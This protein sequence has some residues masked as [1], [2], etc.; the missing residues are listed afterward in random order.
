MDDKDDFLEVT[1]N[2]DIDV[3]LSGRKKLIFPEKIL[4]LKDYTGN[5]KKDGF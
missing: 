4:I 3:D 5:T 2:D 1:E